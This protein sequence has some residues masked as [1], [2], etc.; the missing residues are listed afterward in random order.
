MKVQTLWYL[1]TCSFFFHDCDCPESDIKAD[2]EAK[3][4]LEVDLEFECRLELE[5]YL[6]NGTEMQ[7]GA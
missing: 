6:D 3:L 7:L 5:V 1:W 2:L 4:D